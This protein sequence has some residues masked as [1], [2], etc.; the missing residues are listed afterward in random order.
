MS[1]VASL[2]QDPVPCTARPQLYSLPPFAQC[3]ASKFDAR[4]ESQGGR[5]NS[6]R[7]TENVVRRIGGKLQVPPSDADRMPEHGINSGGI[8][9][10][11]GRR[12]AAL[13][14]ICLGITKD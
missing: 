14:P 12:Q 7:V 2:R 10:L 13:V 1:V 5:L 11:G 6:S 9:N 3:C 4:N 8:W